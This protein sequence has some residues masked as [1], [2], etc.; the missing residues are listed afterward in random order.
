M[1]TR[2]I[3][4]APDDPHILG[5]GRICSLCGAGFPPLGGSTRNPREKSVLRPVRLVRKPS[6]MISCIPLQPKF[7]PSPVAIRAT[8]VSIPL[9]TDITQR[10]VGPRLV[11][12][13][14]VQHTRPVSQ[15]AYIYR[16]IGTN[17][18]RKYFA[19]PYPICIV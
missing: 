17:G 7:D 6:F 8:T 5:E 15:T 2:H 12:L 11:T 14:S 9:S 16:N 4:T 18:R 1:L 13:Y 19:E 3:Y 10:E